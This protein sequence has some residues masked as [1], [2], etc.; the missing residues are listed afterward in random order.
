MV[1]LRDPEGVSERLPVLCAEQVVETRAWRSTDVTI[2]DGQKTIA[3][4]NI[5]CASTDEERIFKPNCELRA[6]D[7]WVFV[8]SND[9]LQ[10]PGQ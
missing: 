3:H 8:D 5:L 7:F 10:E 9:Q 6:G 1:D 2:K 4:F